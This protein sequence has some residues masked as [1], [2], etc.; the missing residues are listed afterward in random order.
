MIRE[1]LL[2]GNAEPREVS[3]LEMHGTGTPLGDPIEMGAVTAVFCSHEPGER[4]GVQPIWMTMNLRIAELHSNSPFQSVW[5][6]RVDSDIALGFV[7]S[8]TRMKL[9][10]WRLAMIFP[11]LYHVSKFH[12]SFQEVPGCFTPPHHARR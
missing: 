7:A 1:A 9:R 3:A 11:L 12:V 6:Q 5:K 8:W 2:E 10:A 4:I